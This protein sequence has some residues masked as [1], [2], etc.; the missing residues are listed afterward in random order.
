MTSDQL[1]H[2]EDCFYNI[3]AYPSLYKASEL[4]QITHLSLKE[5]T[6]SFIRIVFK[7]KF[8]ITLSLILRSFKCS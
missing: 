4:A 8:I 2:M 5:L 3:T 1:N 6:V 7:K